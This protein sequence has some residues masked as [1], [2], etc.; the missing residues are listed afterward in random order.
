MI[1]TRRLRRLI[2]VVLAT[3]QS[4]SVIASDVQLTV[5]ADDPQ[6]RVSPRLIGVFFEDI[7]FGADGG[8][9]AEL[10]KNGGFEF[11]QALMGWSEVGDADAGSAAASNESPFATSN[12]NFLRIEARDGGYGVANEGFRGMGVRA[13]EQYVFAARARSIAGREALVTV[14]VVSA[15]GAVLAEGEFTAAGS[16]WKQAKLELTPSATD[17]RAHLELIVGSR[18][19][20]DLDLVSL[21]PAKTWMNRP[22]GLRADVVQWLADLKPA[23]FRF[24]GGCI[25]EGS[26]LKY[27]YQ[28]KTTVGSLVDRRLIVNRWNTEFRHRL[29]PDYYQTFALGFF[30]YFQLA[31]DLGAEPLPILNCGMACQFNSGELVPIAELDPYIQDALDL[32]EFAN[33]SADTQWGRLRAQMGHPEPF[34]MRLLGVGNEQWGQEYIERYEEFAAVL[35]ERHPEIELVSGSGPFPEDPKFNYAWPE[36]RRLNADIVD[37]HCYAMPDWFLRSAQRY[38]AYDRSGPEVFMGEYAAQSVGITSPNN[39]NNLRCALSEAAFLSGIERNSDIVTM[40]S[41]APLFGHEDAWQW[42]PNLLWFDNLDSYGTPNYYVQQLF[43]L[44]RGDVVL[45][46]GLIDLARTAERTETHNLVPMIE[47][48]SSVGRLGLFVHVTAGFGDV[49]FCGYWT[50]EMFATQ[51]VRI[52]A[53]VPIC[54]IFYHEITGDVTEYQSDKYQHNHDIQPSLLFKELNPDAEA[55]EDPQLQLEFGVERSHS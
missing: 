53:G 55:E 36:L 46:I 25:V 20:V 41:Y 2:L 3:T 22:N 28:W 24:P 39:R 19:T 29:T 49:G 11:P 9:V 26:Q 45:P 6:H 33:G 48:R 54:Q 51:P 30:E 38:D 43:S 7:N 16:E 35:K 5:R 13:D 4:L 27:R 40:S 47:G 21:C 18:G 1:C 34:N 44:H 14:R 50:L 32:I 8:L 17:K 12:A 23:F 10:I 15:E 37:E 52:Y 42:R 31:E